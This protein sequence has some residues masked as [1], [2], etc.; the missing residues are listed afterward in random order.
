[1]AVRPRRLPHSTPR[2]NR[3]M[4]STSATIARSARASFASPCA[5]SRARARRDVDARALASSA[6]LVPKGGDIL[7]RPTPSARA[8][9]RAPRHHRRL[10][11][12]RL[13]ASRDETHPD[14]PGSR[15]PLEDLTRPGMTPWE[16]LGMDETAP[17]F[18]PAV[19]D[20]KAAYR[21]RMRRYHP[22]V[23]D[24]D[25]D[26]EA[27]TRRVLAAYAAVL[28][29]DATRSSVDA[30]AVSSDFPPWS[31]DDADP[32]ESPEGPADVAFVDPFLCRGRACP[33]YCCCVER[34]PAGFEW[35]REGVA[36]FRSD[37]AS[38]GD[39]RRADDERA[40]YDMHLAVGQC[41]TEAIAWVTP[42]QREALEALVEYAASTGD[43]EGAARRAR[44]LSAKAAFENG[45]AAAPATRRRPKR[46]GRWVDW[47]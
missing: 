35:T 36:R 46:S 29:D 32:F 31:S 1:M 14:P 26:A 42:R 27:M 40:A 45:R 47:Y 41:P 24:G 18:E 30:A 5:P 12:R 6:S 28:G 17:S 39:R 9:P 19:A 20:V 33:P 37:A 22:D 13:A 25:G 11:S 7:A 23:Y 44:E 10:A 2:A 21:A 38:W 4:A 43:A 3:D 8:P 16:V 15:E 34:H